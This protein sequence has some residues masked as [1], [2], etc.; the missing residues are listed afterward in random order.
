[1]EENTFDE[2][3]YVAFRLGAGV[4]GVD[5]SRV[6]EIIVHR[7][8]TRVPGV[9]ELVEGVINLRGHVIPIY[10]LRKQFAFPE[11][12]KTGD[13]RM[14]VVEVQD[15]TIGIVVDEVSE[16]LMIPGSVVEKPSA[17]ISTGVDNDYIAGIAK[18]EENL[19][20]ILDLERVLGR[21]AAKVG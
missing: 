12:E 7:E 6:R 14:V 5:I 10:S 13:T 18:M 3:Q 20:I 11:T 9:S 15:S 16:V 1:V 17:M 4:F 21:D 19:V 8:P 2:K